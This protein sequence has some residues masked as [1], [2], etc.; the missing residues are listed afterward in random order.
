[1]KKRVGLLLIAI[2]ICFFS[3]GCNKTATI[4]THIFETDLKSDS[5]YTW[6]SLRMDNEYIDNIECLVDDNIVYSKYENGDTNL[7]FYNFEV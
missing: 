1:M 6:K 2:T 4:D 5:G 7:V 3:L